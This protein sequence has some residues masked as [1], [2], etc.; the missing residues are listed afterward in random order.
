MPSVRL[1]SN[2]ITSGRVISGTNR[3]L[4]AFAG[5]IGTTGFPNVS[6]M[7]VVSME[8]YDVCEL[9]ARSV[10]RFMVLRSVLEISMTTTDP[11]CELDVLLRLRVRETVPGWPFCRASEGVLMVETN[12]DSE[13]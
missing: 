2:A 13:N 3:S 11:F 10:S 4:L 8:T 7:K 6:V 5:A 1:R 12:T 9:T